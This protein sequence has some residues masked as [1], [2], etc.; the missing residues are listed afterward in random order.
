MSENCDIFRSA[1]LVSGD[2]S[3]AALIA[4]SEGGLHGG[5]LT[6]A[7]VL[8]GGYSYLTAELLTQAL[9]V[10]KIFQVGDERGSGVQLIVT[11]STGSEAFLLRTVE[12]TS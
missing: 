1:F 7:L 4:A 11:K 12:R 10:L 3:I 2:V 9:V 6:T 8:F 5:D